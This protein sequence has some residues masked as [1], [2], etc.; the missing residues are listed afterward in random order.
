MRTSLLAWLGALLVTAALAGCSH[1][2]LSTAPPADQPPAAST[3][4]GAVHRFE[5]AINHRDVD[6]VAELLTDDFQF[7]GAA[8]DSA[9]NAARGLANGRE[10]YLAALRSL[11]APPNQVTFVFDRNP[12]P[13]PDSR[14]GKLPNWHEQIR[15]TLDL[16]V[17]DASGNKI[18]QIHGSGLFFCTRGDSAAI[19]AEL[20]ARGFKPDST[21]WWLD[22][23]EDET[24]AG[25][26]LPSATDPARS[27]SLTQLLELYYSRL[28]P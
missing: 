25:G 22:R 19:P 26:G 13:F 9:G 5:W 7:I 14:P 18:H 12:I 3:P 21:Q 4:A 6:L 20:M 15:T 2:T 11:L 10:R 1:T 16:A 24:P 17:R 28:A 8:T 23:Y 27:I